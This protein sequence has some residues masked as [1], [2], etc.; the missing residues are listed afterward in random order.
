MQPT[1]IH[2]RVGRIAALARKILAT[3][4]RKSSSATFRK[5]V[6]LRTAKLSA[7]LRGGIEP[8]TGCVAETAR[9]GGGLSE[10]DAPFRAGLEAAAFG[11]SAALVPEALL[12]LWRFAI[13]WQRCESA[14]SQRGHGERAWRSGDTYGC[15]MK[16]LSPLCAPL[17]HA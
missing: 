13:H 16:Y 7:S 4:N 5:A 3:S 12:P 2:H 10:P 17:R 11:C 6:G 8:A 14:A 15:V 9:G 1:T